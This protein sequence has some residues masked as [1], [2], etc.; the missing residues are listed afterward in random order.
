MCVVHRDQRLLPA[1]SPNLFNPKLS[2][3]TRLELLETHN[4][5]MEMMCL[6]VTS[7]QRLE[8]LIVQLL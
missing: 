6:H 8:A 5:H 1:G 2:A 3:A 7:T 4:C